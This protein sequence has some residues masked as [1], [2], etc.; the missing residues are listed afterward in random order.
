M[1]FE[2]PKHVR[3]LRIGHASNAHNLADL[4]V[5]TTTRIHDLSDRVSTCPVRVFPI[6]GLLPR[7][8]RKRFP[9]PGG[10]H[11]GA[12]G[13]GGGWGP[14]RYARARKS[15][16]MWKRKRNSTRKRCGS[17]GSSRDISGR[18]GQAMQVADNGQ[19]GNGQKKTARQR[20]GPETRTG[21]RRCRTG[22]GETGNGS[23]YSSYSPLPSLTG[24][25]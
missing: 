17:M 2:E 11:P 16:R 4:A 7:K 14:E 24:G 25:L 3:K 6:L 15:T 22:T 18:G 23:D 10:Q 13:P 19:I 5:I 9:R 1:L 8:R 21:I 12:S 20:A